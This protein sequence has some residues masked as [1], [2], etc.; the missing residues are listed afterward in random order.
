MRKEHISDAL[1]L[2]NDTFIEETGS[3]RSCCRMPQNN[4]ARQKIHLIAGKHWKWAAVA[5]C[6]TLAL[7]VGN[8]MLLQKTSDTN[9]TVQTENLPMLSITENTSDDMGFEG[10]LANDISELINNN[11]WSETSQPSALPVY[12]NPL[13]YDGPFHVMGADFGKMR[14]F[15]IDIAGRLGIDTNSLTIADNEPDEEEKRIVTEKMEGDVPEGYFNPTELIGR[16][17]GI[18]ITVDRTMRAVVS[19]E[20]AISLP[21][22]YN[23]T[24]GAS[25]EETV[26]VAEYLQERYQAL[27]QMKNPQMNICGG[28]YSS[29]ETGFGF[30][31]E[32]QIEFYDK[33]EN[34]ID[35][36]INYNFNNI[37]FSCDDD[38]KLYLASICQL[39]LS[40]KMGDYPVINTEKAKELLRK[41]NYITTVPYK[42]P[43]ENFIAKTELVYRTGA[44]EE[45]FMPY[46]CFYVELPEEERDGLKTYGAYYVPA[47]DKEYLTNMP[48]WDGSFN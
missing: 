45:Y 21:K 17:N 31:Q 35:A 23:F 13:S 37:E 33:G 36:M 42:I 48:F 19:F 6:L 47:V 15:L 14:E 8:Q 10:Y 18:E 27:I 34:D 12:K 16:T 7:L 22:K 32:Y 39:D 30:L 3:L 28:D 26:A 38:G 43:G 41:G 46:Y 4:T 29:Y 5:A 1:N 40:Q 25:Y 20:P 44:R 24:D 9:Q 2:L 11:P